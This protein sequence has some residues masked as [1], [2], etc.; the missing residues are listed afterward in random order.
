MAIA[1]RSEPDGAVW[2]GDGDLVG[3]G[4][5]ENKDITF[6]RADPAH[7]DDTGIGLTH[8]VVAATDAVLADPDREGSLH[9]EDAIAGLAGTLDEP[10]EGSMPGLQTRLLVILRE[11]A[12]APPM[13]L[14]GR[15]HR[16]W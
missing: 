8:C 7:V 1:S 4:V 2:R 13:R 14:H 12:F 6:E 11:E 16:G 5:S 9:R 3:N 10:L 15:V